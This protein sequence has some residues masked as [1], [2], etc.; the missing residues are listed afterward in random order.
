MFHHL[1]GMKV[2]DLRARQIERIGR[3]ERLPGR[4]RVIA[5]IPL[6]CLHLHYRSLYSCLALVIIIAIALNH[7]IMEHL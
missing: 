2:L 5:R 4:W 1:L 7:F 3:V 6:K